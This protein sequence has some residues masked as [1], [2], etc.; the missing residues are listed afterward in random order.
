MKRY[1][2][3]FITLILIPTVYANGLTMSL[4]QKEYY[5]LV[6]EEAEIQLEIENT[7]GK[8]ISGQLSYTITQEVNQAGF[9]Y[10]NSNTQSAKFSIDKDKT[11]SMLRF[12]TSD[13]PMTIRVSMSFSYAEKEQMQVDMDEITVHF[14]ADE[15][16]KNNKQE[17]TES[18]SQ[19]TTEPKDTPKR[20]IQKAQERLQNNQLAQ[21]SSALKSQMQEELQKKEDMKKEFQNNIA[22]NQK[23]QEMHNELLNE[24][25]NV[26]NANLDPTTAD[27]GQFE[28]EYQ[29][30]NGEAASIKGE[31][32]KGEITKLQKQSEQDRQDMLNSIRDN[33]RFQRY[34]KSLARDDFE[35]VSVDFEQIENKTI[36]SLN[37]QNNMNESALIRAEFTDK[38]ITKI[39]L[40]DSRQSY[41]WWM[42]LA[43]VMII[44]YLIYFKVR[45][46]EKI[47]PKTIKE[48][49]FNYKKE[50][51]KL[52]AHAKRLFS[53]G[54]HKDAYG[55]SGQGIRLFLSYENGLRKEVTNDEIVSYLRKHRKRHSEVKECF[56]LC[57]LV[58]FAKYKANKKDFEKIIRL[59]GKIMKS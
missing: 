59:A 31:M 14:V 27:T 38:E 23:F 18:E 57:S 52:I 19:E 44:G 10:S 9:Q 29:K 47:M 49:P 43:L 15:S 48:K 54:R 5:F 7:H 17:K 16:E 24:G 3:L 2:I 41:I 11:N 13:S 4:E 46:H 37:Y 26:T 30:Q 39:E 34:N 22:N 28:V 25:Y 8:E 53:E 45:K 32:E 42:L 1:F 50:S 20:D 33:D 58:E 6:G 51:E 56:D 35:Q 40:E 55:K 21:D 12:G 36:V